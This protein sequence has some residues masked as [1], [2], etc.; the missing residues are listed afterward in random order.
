MPRLATLHGAAST[1]PVPAWLRQAISD[2]QS[3]AGKDV[4][5]VALVT[6]AAIG[7]LDTLVR[8]QERFAGAWRQRY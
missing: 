1:A 7:A 5:E 2:L 3:L 8:R 6:G 4:A